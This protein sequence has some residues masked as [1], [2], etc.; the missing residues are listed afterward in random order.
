MVR[1]LDPFL[2]A[3]GTQVAIIVLAVGYQLAAGSVTKWI[4]HAMFG[5]IGFLFIFGVLDVAA[6]ARQTRQARH[7]AC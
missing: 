2:V 6:L 3:V 7:P 1:F 5:L 4:E